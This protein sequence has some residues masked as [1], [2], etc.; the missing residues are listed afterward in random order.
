MNLLDA[1]MAETGPVRTSTYS[2]SIDG[3]RPWKGSAQIQDAGGG[4]ETL[5]NGND[6][7][8]AQLQNG[9]SAVVVSEAGG[10]PWRL[11]F[12]G[13]GAKVISDARARCLAQR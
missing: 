9:K 12:G 13:T 11:S 6:E 1:S 2:I 10:W 3:G 5:L 8:I 4:T 7:L